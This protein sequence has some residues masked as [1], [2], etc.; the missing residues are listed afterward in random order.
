MDSSGHISVVGS[1]GLASELEMLWRWGH[2]GERNQG[3]FLA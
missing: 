2:E 1:A 3:D